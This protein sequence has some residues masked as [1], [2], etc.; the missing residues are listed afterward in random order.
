MTHRMELDGIRGLAIA[1]VVLAHALYPTSLFPGG[2]VVGVQLFFVLSG[3]LITSILA[4]EHHRRG[5]IDRRRFYTR[6]LRRL[7]PALI[8]F[9]VAFTG[10]AI[11]AGQA[12]IPQVIV[13]LTYV[14][15]WAQ[16]GG[17]DLSELNHTWSL[18]VEEQF[19]LIWPFALALL[20]PRW[21]LVGAVALVLWRPALAATGA[22]WDRLYYATDVNAA[23]LLAGAALALID[24]PRAP[25]WLGPVAIATLLGLSLTMTTHTASGQ[26]ALVVLGF[27]IGIVASCA[28]VVAAL[29]GSQWLA[30]RPLVFLGAISYG[31]Y[32][33]HT[34]LNRILELDYGWPVQA[35]LV[36]IPMSIA[37]AWVSLH[38][39][40]S[41]FRRPSGAKQAAQGEVP[42]EPPTSV[43]SARVRPQESSGT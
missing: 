43:P 10:W 5:V 4:E 28:L 18:A 17:F 25:N 31:L 38:F 8:V 20:R 37:V 42:I 24:M 41:R 35:R 1:L 21:V 40:E 33:W 9:L 23:P 12:R 30:A 7:L 15:N 3:F 14:S 13:G 6:R 36:L 19:Y 29:S 26:A 27:P 34:G 39:V 11:A 32:L 16:V 2:G 22:S